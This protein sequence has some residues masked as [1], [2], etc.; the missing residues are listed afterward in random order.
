ME[1]MENAKRSVG[2]GKGLALTRLAGNTEPAFPTDSVR[3]S[4]SLL[5]MMGVTTTP[6]TEELRTG[7]RSR[8]Y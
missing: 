7:C 8:L 5:G 4:R 3:A 2:F 6:S 1:S